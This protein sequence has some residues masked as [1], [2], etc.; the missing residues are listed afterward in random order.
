MAT[1]VDPYF[2]TTYTQQ[3]RIGYIKTRA[4][5]ELEKMVVQQEAAVPS[6]AATVQDEPEPEI[7]ASPKKKKTLSSYFDFQTPTPN[8]AP[9][10]RE[11]IEKELNLYVLLP[12]ATARPG[13]KEME[14]LKWWQ[15]NEQNFPLVA[16]LAR[17]YLCV[18]ATS[19]PSERVFSTSGNIVTCHRATL[20]PSRVEELTFLARNLDVD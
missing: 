3:E 14:P 13:Q 20:K 17:K 10:T 16:K 5:A 19:S 11:V 15:E 18:P 9:P 8:R 1:F 6:P 7:P 2:K 4:A 12:V